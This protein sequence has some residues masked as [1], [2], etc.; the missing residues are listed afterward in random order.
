M[1]S[2]RSQSYYES[3]CPDCGYRNQYTGTYLVVRTLP[4]CENGDYNTSLTSVKCQ[5]CL[6][7]FVP[8]KHNTSSFARNPI[9]KSDLTPAQIELIALLRSFVVIASPE[10]GDLQL[11]Q[12]VEQLKYDPKFDTVSVLLVDKVGS[13]DENTYYCITG[14]NLTGDLLSAQLRISQIYEIHPV[15]ALTFHF[16]ELPI[17][18]GDVSHAFRM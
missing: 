7:I 13:K 1:L 2:K 18:S 12:L 14:Q 3:A 15:N 6:N 10:V 17:M 9:K 5:L 4:S 8:T 16:D 11:N